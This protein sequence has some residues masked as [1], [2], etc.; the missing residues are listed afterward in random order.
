ML[1][2][3]VPRVSAATGLFSTVAS[4]GGLG[5]K[6]AIRAAAAPPVSQYLSFFFP[7]RN[8][9]ALCLRRQVPVV[10]DERSVHQKSHMAQHVTEG[11]DSGVDPRTSRQPTMHRILATHRKCTATRVLG[12]T[13]GRNVACSLLCTVSYRKNGRMRNPFS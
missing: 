9:Y 1:A 3:S 11:I 4:S 12:S 2:Q 7:V 13:L 6:T 8:R 10:F 5:G